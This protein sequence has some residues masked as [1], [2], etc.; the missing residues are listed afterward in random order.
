MENTF[1]LIIPVAGKEVSFV[2]RVT[3]YARKNLEGLDCIYILTNK[4]HFKKIAKNLK[5][6]RNITLLDED[7]LIDGLTFE[8]I[9]DFVKRYT[10]NVT[11]GWYFQQF[12][13]YAFA[14]TSY[15]KQYY[16]SWDADTIP[17]AKINFFKNGQPLFT[18]KTEYNENYFTTI[19]KIL[20]IAKVVPY[21]F[22]AE[23]MLFNSNIVKEIVEKISACDVEGNTW[24]EKI[25]RAGDY[26]VGKPPYSEF[27]TY[28][29]YVTAYYP[30]LYQIRQ[31]NTFRRGSV[32][33]GRYISDNLLET[34]SFDI[35]T[36]S[37]ELRDKPPFPY[38]IP[39]I[40]WRFKDISY[41]IF[42][43]KPSIIL[44]KLRECLFL[45]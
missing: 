26:S 9:K 33:R 17:I 20:G 1:D 14:F 36:I 4:K 12:L 40:W 38:N 28:G 11:P 24:Y 34:L 8:C 10:N 18:R 16:L 30:N 37:F 19:K 6:Q 5:E 13:K 45:K 41:K 27:E 42:H 43:N 2:H 23:H 22:I 29:T 31:L 25:L 15:A 7:T 35:D 39:Y 3:M 44:Q 21:S 32:I